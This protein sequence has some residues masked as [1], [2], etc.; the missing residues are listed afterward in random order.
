M[1]ATRT[2]GAV[3]E[4]V[5]P[6]LEVAQATANGGDAR[7]SVADYLTFVAGTPIEG[8][9]L[10][11]LRTAPDGL[12]YKESTE[13]YQQ[14]QEAFSAEAERVVSENTTVLPEAEYTKQKEA[15]A[16]LPET[17]EQY[18]AEHPNTRAV[19]EADVKTVEDKILGEFTKAAR[20]TAPVNRLHTTMLTEGYK[21]LAKRLK[22]APSKLFA[23]YPINIQSFFII[24]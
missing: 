21:A 17:Y 23:E 11:E 15:G 9:V 10:Q 19:Y 3:D 6:A 8:A 20:F 12:T 24:P 16:T 2:R 1:R 4:G 7:I 22:T 14:Q 18:V 13:F 5:A